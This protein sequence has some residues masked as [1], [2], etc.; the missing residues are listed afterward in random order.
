MSSAP[1]A[2]LSSR[3][4]FSWD[5]MSP[6]WTDGKGDQ[7]EYRDAVKLWQTFHNRLPESNSNK[8]QAALQAVYLK[9]QLYVRAKDLCS[10]ISD[11]QLTEENAVDLIVG[12]IYQ[13]DALS[14]VNEAY[15]A[16]NQLWNTHHSNSGTMKNF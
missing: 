7:E 15:G 13:K 14:V 2:S 5:A 10:G 4:K 9:S 16:F 1:Q 6:P 8:I 12:K 11:S 3:P